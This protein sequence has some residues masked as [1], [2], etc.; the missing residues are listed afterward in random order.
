M[1]SKYFAV[2]I[3][4]G[5]DKFRYIFTRFK[6]IVLVAATVERINTHDG[7]IVAH[8]KV[9]LSVDGLGG[10]RE[11]D[12]ISCKDFTSL[13]K[14]IETLKRDSLRKEIKHAQAR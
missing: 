3:T 14:A 11:L 12:E 1:N 10:Y 13:R 5:P 4:R 2:D 6:D 8:C 7:F 9:K